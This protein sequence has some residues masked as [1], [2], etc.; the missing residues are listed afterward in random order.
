[1]G[2][3]SAA[4]SNSYQENNK[5]IITAVAIYNNAKIRNSF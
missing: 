1:M 4:Y 3:S 2:L 5:L